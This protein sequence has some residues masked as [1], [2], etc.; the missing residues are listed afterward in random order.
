MG[1]ISGLLAVGAL[2]VSGTVLGQRGAAVYEIDPAKSDLHWLV[3]KAGTL[4]RLGHNHVIS[5][6]EP[7]GA[8]TVDASNLGASQFSIEFPVANLVVDDPALRKG[9]GEP[10]SSVPSESDIA[11]TRRNMLS[12]RVLSGEHFPKIRVR[13]TGPMAAANGQQLSMTVEM[14]GRTMTF[15]VPVKV[16]VDEETVEAQGEFELTHAELGMKPFTVMLGAL[17]VADKMTFIY[18]VYAHRRRGPLE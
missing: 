15:T 18:H 10:F 3:Y 8:V 13:G 17:Q 2:V 11:G 1:R 7:K 16:S 5:V 12:E 4:E 14:L 9:L 6:P